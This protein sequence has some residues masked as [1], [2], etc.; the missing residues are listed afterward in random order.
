M[1]IALVAAGHQTFASVA[2]PRFVGLLEA[3]S[4]AASTA[5]E[6][7]MRRAETRLNRHR[8]F[9]GFNA[10]PDQFNH[11]ARGSGLARFMIPKSG[12]SNTL[13]SPAAACATSASACAL[14]AAVTTAF[15]SR[16]I[17]FTGL[18]LGIPSC[19]NAGKQATDLRGTGS[20]PCCGLPLA[21]AACRVNINC[22][23]P[24]PPI[25][26]LVRIAGASCD[27]H[28]HHKPKAF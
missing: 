16:A 10:L 22:R 5:L 8:P 1:A 12:A 2:A 13:V 19:T 14:D 21:S 24:A 9:E 6:I 23:A 28:Q 27:V 18:E 3:H 11:C 20:T 25:K 4:T 17:R 26:Q 15:H 7:D